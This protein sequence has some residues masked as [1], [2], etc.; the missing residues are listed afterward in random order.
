VAAGMTDTRN[1]T[2]VPKCLSCHLGTQEQFVDHDDR[3][4]PP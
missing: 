2:G 1:L 3:R 4:R